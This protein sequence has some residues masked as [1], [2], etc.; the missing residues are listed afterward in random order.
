MKAP[1]VVGN[2]KM[3]GTESEASSLARHIRS[4]AA[5]VKG[6]D[7]V[8]APPFTALAP[9][10]KLIKGS[11]IQLAGQNFYW[12]PQ[13][14]FTGEISPRML[15]DSGCR[16]VILG[17]SERR[18]LF[19]DSDQDV[20]QKI[21]AAL[22]I[23]LRPILCVGETL[24]ERRKGLTPRVV[25]RQLRIALK[26]VAKSVIQAVEI[27][28][29]PIWAIGTGQNATPDQVS[30]VHA[31]IRKFLRERFGVSVARQIRILYG[32]SVRPDN[33]GELARVPDVNGVLV[34]GAS[35]KPQDFLAIIRCFVPA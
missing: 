21:A 23:G 12:Q 17:H 7:I 5:R 22:E 25:T 8:L 18:R 19:H 16:F 13:G 20:A 2:W 35:L 28:Y 10:R 4:G 9:V 26:G 3:H 11:R 29:E 1:L 14:A 6:V 32:G 24:Q 34:G 30:H 33:A 27:A 31:L 15:G